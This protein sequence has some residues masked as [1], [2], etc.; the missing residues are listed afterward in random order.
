MARLTILIFIAAFSITANGQMKRLPPPKA[1]T[2]K[3]S[4]IE[5]RNHKCI[6]INKYSTGQRLLFYPFSKAVQVKLVSFDLKP[7]SLGMIR[8]LN[9][10]DSLPMK[11][12]MVDYSKLVEIK[13]LT[14]SQIDSL[15]DILY[16]TFYKGPF[17]TIS[18]PC[19]YNP[20]NA[21]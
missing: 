19:C 20:R 2:K 18:E 1:P 3:S 5:A 7:D 12:G 6:H 4:A 14:K 13:V 15:T 9:G 8:L 10:G 11:H 16:N 17:S 21:I